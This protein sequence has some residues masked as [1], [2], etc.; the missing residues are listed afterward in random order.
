MVEYTPC[1]PSPLPLPANPYPEVLAALKEAAREAGSTNSEDFDI[2]FNV[3]IFSPGLK[4]A[5]TEVWSDD[6]TTAIS[7]F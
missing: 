1:D 3:D 6:T 5:D 7:L 4:H 2:Q